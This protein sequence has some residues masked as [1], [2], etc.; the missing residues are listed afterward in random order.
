MDCSKSL[1]PTHTF[2]QLTAELLW[3]HNR[4]VKNLGNSRIS[5]AKIENEGTLGADHLGSV[6][7]VVRADT[8]AIAQAISYDEFGRVLSDS[9]P[10]FQAFGFAGG[11]YD[12]QTSLVRFGA[13]DYDPET[14]RW[15][16]KDPI[17]FNGGD[18]NLF[19]YVANDPINFIDPDG[20]H[21]VLVGAA[22]G[23]FLGAFLTP[24][25]TNTPMS[26]MGEGARVLGGAAAGAAVGGMCAAAATGAEIAIGGMRFAPFGNR[27]GNPTG[28][29]PHYHRRTVDPTTGQPAPGQGIGRH[30]PWDTRST[31]RSFWDRF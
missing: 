18:T 26:P 8:G 30:R 3:V 13:R 2:A 15:L 1:S 10:G 25:P 11:L 17:L 24:T 27:T 23:A 28:E 16:S 20:E 14:G 21:P 5:L 19:G 31:D 7:L 29:L 6:R 12:H 22:I 4:I 9:S